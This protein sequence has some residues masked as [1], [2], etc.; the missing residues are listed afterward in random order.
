MFLLQK[1]TSGNILGIGRKFTTI[2][3]SINK[4]R[5]QKGDPGRDP[6]PRGGSHSWVRGGSWPPPVCA[7]RTPPCDALWPINY[8]RRK[9]PNPPKIFPNTIQSSAAIA[10]KFRGFR[11][12]CS[13]I[14]SGR[15]STAGAI[16]INTAASRDEE[17]V[18][19]H[20]G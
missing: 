11:R 1:V 14:L 8:P 3:Y 7:P 20:R 5:S 18:V 4:D 10:D 2:F 13:G 15:G 17:G 19:P 9:S 6:Q 12:S 16:S